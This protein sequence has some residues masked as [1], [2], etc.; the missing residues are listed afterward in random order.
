M[1]IPIFIDTSSF[2]FTNVSKDNIEK[3]CDNI[4]KGLAYS[5]SQRLTAEANNALHRTKKR[6]INAITLVDSGRMQGT[7]LL[8][9]SKDKMVKMI[10]EGA[11]PFDMKIK[12]L[13]GA[14]VKIGKNGGRY[15]TI[16]FRVGTPDAVGESDAFTSI[17]P[18]AIYQVVKG[19]ETNIVTPTGSRSAGLMMK[20]LPKKYQIPNTRAAITD[21][22]GKILFDAYTNK[23]PLFLGLI[24]SRDAVT[25]QNKYNTFRRVSERSDK[26]AFIHPGIERYNL[27][28]KALNNF[29]QER[30]VSVQLSN[31]LAKLGLQ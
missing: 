29:N 21:S 25:G 12:M 10:E 26:N 31:E 2:V 27:I 20:E 7:V 15:L 16:P 9:Y 14:K 30:E 28:S 5:Y 6:Y 22:K 17:M 11:T 3:M 8:D 4:A 19:K 13:Q 24:K 23:S 18:D 1:L